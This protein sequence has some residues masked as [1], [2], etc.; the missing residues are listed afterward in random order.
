MATPCPNPVDPELF[1]LDQARVNRGQ[2][3]PEALRCEIRELLQQRTL[4]T[5]RKAGLDRIE[6]EEVGKLH[7]RTRDWCDLR[8]W[9]L[10]WRNMFQPARGSTQPMFPSSRR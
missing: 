7:G 1:A 5:G 4:V 10:D 8:T 9:P 2:I 6:I 3:S